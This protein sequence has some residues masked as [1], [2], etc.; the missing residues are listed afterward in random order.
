MA[1]Q[2]AAGLDSARTRTRGRR[3]VHFTEGGDEVL[4]DTEHGPLSESQAVVARAG[5]SAAIIAQAARALA[6]LSLPTSR[7]FFCA[8]A[9]SLRLNLT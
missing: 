6:A 8:P 3:D 7:T 4:L 1:H 5:E 9:L 2:S